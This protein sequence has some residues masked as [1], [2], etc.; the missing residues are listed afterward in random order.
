[1]AGGVLDVPQGHTS[2][3]GGG[4]EAMPQ[5]VRADPLVD[6]SSSGES[7]HCSVSG[8]AVHS[9][10]VGPQ[11]DRTGYSFAN[12]KLDGSGGARGQR[13]HC[14]LASLSGYPQD[15]V[16]SLETEIIDVSVQRFGHP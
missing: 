5:A 14:A 9:L 10:S 12:V 7:F 6:P 16:A 13:D 15:V 8:V 1:M 3:E 11:E 4:D 2:I